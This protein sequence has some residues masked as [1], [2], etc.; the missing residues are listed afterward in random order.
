MT[1]SGAAISAALDF[2]HTGTQ[3]WDIDIETDQGPL[4]LS[5]GGAKLTVGND[6]VPPDAGALESEYEAI[7]PPL[8]GS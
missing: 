2:R 5:A 7:L 8:C 1:D 4:K 3:T 6:A